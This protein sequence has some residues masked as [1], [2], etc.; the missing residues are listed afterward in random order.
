MVAE[1]AGVDMAQAFAML[2][3]HARNH[4]LRLRTSPAT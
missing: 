4:N 1:R 2:R 3:N